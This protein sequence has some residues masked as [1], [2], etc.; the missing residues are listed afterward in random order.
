M[1]CMYC[2]IQSEVKNELSIDEWKKAGKILNQLGIKD[3]VI[4]G[5]E[6][7]KYES[8]P[9]LIN[10]FENEMGI[11]CSITTNAYNNYAELLNVIDSGLSQLG[12]SIDNLNFKK[13][14]SPLKCREGLLLIDKLKS[15]SINVKLVNYLVLNKKNCNDVEDLIKYMSELGITT[16]IL[17][18]HHSNENEFEHR[19]NNMPFAF[20]TDEEIEMY[21]E[22][23]EKIKLM[24]KMGYLI[25]NSIEFFDISK[26]HIKMLDWKCKGLSELRIDSDGMVACCCDKL[27]VVNKKYSIF[28]LENDDLFEEFIKTREADA[29]SC[30]GC[31]WPSSIEAEIRRDKL[32]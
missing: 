30:D 24:K 11:K 12:V 18:F 25:S 7:T 5:G 21:N 28:D 19:K 32:K 27:G 8:L 4:L 3:L 6:P 20:I 14:I 22:A 23:V 1:N 15:K 10:Y 2:N 26:K 16:Y 13:S 9:E 31:L 17:P 29:K